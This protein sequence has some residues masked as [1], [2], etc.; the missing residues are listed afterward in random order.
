MPFQK[1]WQKNLESNKSLQITIANEEQFPLIAELADSIWKEHYTPIIGE[2]QVVYM[3]DK[4]Y[5]L[6]SMIEQSKE[7]QLFHIL[8]VEGI[9]KG[10]YSISNKGN[11]HWFLHKLYLDSSLRGKRL[12]EYMMHT[13]EEYILSQV[14]QS[15]IVISLTV[16]RENFKSINFYF[17]QGFLI[18]SVENF[19]IGR[20]Y[21]MNDFVMKK[22]FRLS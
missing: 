15:E 5:S 1:T 13:I 14:H 12:G 2:E 8:W 11:G 6:P 21:E 19:D 10:F 7:G 16:N 4:F 17:R 3:L 20:G 22:K 9:A 18:D